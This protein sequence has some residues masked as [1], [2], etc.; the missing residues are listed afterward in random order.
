MFGWPA[1]LDAVRK[2][3]DYIKSKVRFKECPGTTWTVEMVYAITNDLDFAKSS[4]KTQE[5]RV[6][7]LE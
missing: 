3:G 5:E 4:A 1:F 6:P 2:L 7:F